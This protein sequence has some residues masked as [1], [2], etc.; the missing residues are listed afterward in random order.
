[1]TTVSGEH[2]GFVTDRATFLSAARRMSTGVRVKV[3]GQCGAQD[4]QLKLCSMCK[5]VWYCNEVHQRQHWSQHKPYCISKNTGGK[6]GASAKKN[7]KKLKKKTQETNF[8]IDTTVL[9]EVAG[10]QAAAM[11]H[12]EMQFQGNG[13]QGRGR[14]KSPMPDLSTPIDSSHPLE[15]SS[16]VHRP[17]TPPLYFVQDSVDSQSLEE[18]GFSQEWFAKVLQDVIRDLNMFGVCVVDD[19]LGK[20]RLAD[21]YSN[22]SR[23][24]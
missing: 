7:G 17:K 16:Q 1:M 10:S 4:D 6:T 3:C 12:N 19:F 23:W 9:D 14:R 8:Y 20:Y 24:Q 18:G 13:G 2:F 11:S 22:L 5:M 21:V 15:A